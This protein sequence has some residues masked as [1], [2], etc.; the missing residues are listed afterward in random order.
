MGTLTS[1]PLVLKARCQHRQGR[2]LEAGV[3]V[4]GKG[5]WFSQ[6]SCSLDLLPGHHG[7]NHIYTLPAPSLSNKH[8]IYEVV[9]SFL[10]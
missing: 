1:K 6:T 9:Y 5:V 3:P 8:N 4:I 2:E 10:K 7:K